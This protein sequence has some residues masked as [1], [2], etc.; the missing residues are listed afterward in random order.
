MVT[1]S[2]IADNTVATPFPPRLRGEWGF[3]AIVDGVL[4]DTGHSGAAFHNATL[5]NLPTTFETIVLSHAHIDHTA[6]L[7]SFLRSSDDPTLY[8][9]PDLWVPRYVMPGDGPGEIPPGGVSIGIPYAKETIAGLATLHDHRQP[10]EV[11]DGMFA[12]GEIPREHSET[13]A[14]RIRADGTF[15]DDH[16]ID[17]QAL[18]I[19][20]D[21][22]VA[23]VLGCCHSGLRNSIEYAEAVCADQVRYVIGGTHLVGVDK[24]EI[25]ELG[26]WLD[27]KL[28]VFAGTHCTG[29]EAQS[30]LSDRLPDAFQTVGVGSTIELP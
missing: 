1:I 17:D 19:T 3:S 23:L 25:L 30:I 2:I 8:H 12:L 20:T 16:V 26:D 27:G 18:A 29:F 7:L 13:T 10:V 21:D 4:F 9:H 24:A 5:L 28:D 6:G 15:I 11:A 22:G 14:G